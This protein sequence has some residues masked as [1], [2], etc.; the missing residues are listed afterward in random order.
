MQAPAKTPSYPW[1][2]LSSEAALLA[3]LPFAGSLNALAFEAGYLAF[4]DVPIYLVRLDLVRIV[5][6]SGVVVFL[7]LFAAMLLDMV[8][9]VAFFVGHR[10]RPLLAKLAALVLLFGPLNYAAFGFRGLLLLIPLVV[11]IGVLELLK[12]LTERRSTP[13]GARAA[14]S[15]GD[16]NGNR[17]SETAFDRYLVT[18]LVLLFFGGCIIFG[19]G[20]QRAHQKVDYWVA[21]DDPTQ[22]LVEQYGEFFVF[23]S[24]DPV[25]KRVGHGLTVVKAGES[26]PVGLRRVRIGP[27]LPATNSEGT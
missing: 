2:F 7:L 20:F 16:G 19:M 27:L 18:P 15:Q 10:L 6:A 9:M 26:T 17:R 22:L 3:V 11:M 23:K 12:L 1:S 8:G 14:L 25:T 13:P 24:F 5:V 4:F 21:T